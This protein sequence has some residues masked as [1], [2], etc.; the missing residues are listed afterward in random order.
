MSVE[1]HTDFRELERVQARFA[2]LA[3]KVRNPQDLLYT[4]ASL[5]ETQTKR[6]ISDEKTAPDG[7]AWQEWSP[8][9]ARTRK[10]KHSLLV[11]SQALLDDIQSTVEGGE[12]VTFAT[13]AYAGAHQDSQRSWLPSRPFLGISASNADEI[14]D[15]VEAWVNGQLT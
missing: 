1:I 13:M 6:R 4:V 15:V 7:R 8:D 10:G 12:A 3:S 9:Y 2:Q 14:I 11:D 5:T